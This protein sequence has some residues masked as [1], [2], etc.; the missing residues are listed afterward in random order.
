M[1]ES[2]FDDLVYE[3][4]REIED[5]YPEYFRRYPLTAP[6]LPLIAQNYAN[7]PLL[8]SYRRE[9][10]E[11]ALHYGFE[12]LRKKGISVETGDGAP[13]HI[14]N[15]FIASVLDAHLAAR[16][17]IS[18]RA[19]PRTNASL[20]QILCG[21]YVLRRTTNRVCYL[22]GANEAPTVLVI[23]ASGVPLRVWER[24]LGDDSFPGR[25]LIVHT[26][27]TPLIE[28]GVLAPTSI[29]E[30]VED[31]MD[32][33]V[34][35]SLHGVTV[36]AWCTGA[37]VAIELCRLVP[38]R[39]ASLLLVSPTFHGSVDAREYPSPFE[40][41]LPGVYRMLQ[42]ESDRPAELLQ[43]ICQ[44]APERA[45][46]KWPNDPS[47]RGAALLGLPPLF[48]A[49]DLLLPLSTM[50]SF[51]NYIQRARNDATYNLSAAVAAISCPI[52]LL[53]GTHDSET[54]TRAARDFLARWGKNATHFTLISAG[55]HIHILQ[56]SYFI[57]VLEGQLSQGS[58]TDT[59]R[60]MV[61]RL[62]S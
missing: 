59:V 9:E 21:R 60:L 7:H 22:I 10:L 2:V 62:S 36:L 5:R 18:L 45:L 38:E 53:T 44:P 28:G 6:S 34:S 42:G 47:R 23:S 3:A 57:Q 24:L 8:R 29:A 51:G 43:Q 39:V 54:N 26:R 30:D 49:R 56:Y 14:T 37:R 20:V 61:K 1:S 35:E 55:H 41:H 13:N 19:L 31:L 4:V 50:N 16:S 12:S 33:L 58:P 52:A 48:L 11:T 17:A 27:G 25:C 40:D 15:L 46:E 32:V